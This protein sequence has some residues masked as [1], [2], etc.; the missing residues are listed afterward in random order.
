M[1]DLSGGN[2]NKSRSII[3]VALVHGAMLFV[4]L[5]PF[6]I[7]ELPLRS[8]PLQV[9]LVPVPLPVPPPREVTVRPLPKSIDKGGG[10]SPGATPPRQRPD[11]TL[12]QA[13]IAPP[14]PPLDLVALPTTLPVPLPGTG[15]STDAGDGRSAGTGTGDGVGSGSGS[16]SGEGSGGGPKASSNGAYQVADWIEKPDLWL[17]RYYPPRAL[18]QGAVGK[19]TLLCRISRNNKVRGCRIL[20]ES[21]EGFGFGE[22]ALRAAPHFR[23]RPP[24]VDGRPQ[25]DDP[26]VIPLIWCGLEC[27]S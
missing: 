24:M 13:A 22:A 15:A 12:T 16:G 4:L 2:W 7:A 25:L 9:E 1:A 26:T 11:S 20:S 14:A 5:L 3:L 17:R 19:V 10:G 21:P 18:R 27:S 8:D 6:E 23:V